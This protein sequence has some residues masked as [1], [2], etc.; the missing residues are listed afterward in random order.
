MSFLYPH[1]L[2]FLFLPALLAGLVA[3]A[4]RKT[5]NGWLKLVSAEH[6]DELVTRR[7]AWRSIIPAALCIL[8]LAC[9]IAALAR[10]INGFRE[11]GGL[12]T[13][14]NLLIALDISRSM[15]TQDVKP[16][17][18]EEARAAAYEL[19]DSLPSDKIG[20]IVFSGDAD[21]VVP[22]TY[23]HTALRDA[24][25]QVNRNWAGTGGT[26]FGLVLK[27]A[28][29]DLKRSA[30]D[31]TNA[32]V[33]LSDGEDTVGSS[34][35]IAEE[36][37][38]DKLLVI[39][40]GVGT[41]AGGPIPDPKGQNGLWQD[42]DG[43]HVISKL[44]ADSLRRFSEATGGDF[45]VLDSNTDLAAF[46]KNAV[47]KIDKHEENVSTNKVPNDLFAWFAWVALALLAAAIVIA[48][49]WRLPR[50]GAAA[51]AL[52]LILSPAA[53]AAPSGQSVVQYT[54]G[55]MQEGKDNANAKEAFS[56]ALLD[57]D[58]QMQAA[59]FYQIGNVGAN[60]T[61]DKLRRLYGEGEQE[62][63][64]QVST[65]P[66]EEDGAAAPQGPKQP[67][68]EDLEKVVEELKK[69]LLPYENALKIQPGLKPAESNIA[70]IKQLIKDLE[71]E[72]ERLKQQQQQQQQNQD[73]NQD[74]QQQQNQDQQQQNQQ[75]QNKDNQQ[76]QDQKDQQDQDQQQQNQ[77]QQNQQDKQDQD[78][79]QKDQDR[80]QQQGQQDRD[81]QQQQ[82]QNQD[83]QQ[84]QEQKEQQAKP[85]RE[86]EQPKPMTEE[87][88]A[89]Q[90]AADIL[91][92]HLD[93]E[94]GSPIPH[95]P[96]NTVRPPRKDY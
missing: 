83:Q 24:L 60:A 5:G 17:R 4:R 61:I 87:E 84:Q 63:G 22:L 91:R 19:I 80:Q 65:D 9:T 76:K 74:Q 90:S 79:Q 14:R 35:D 71:E 29:Q 53:Q 38:K 96:A 12:S 10:P 2:W 69:D 92:M 34:L 55:L 88:K 78:Q 51:V 41:A 57:S 52:L 47:R 42:A 37:R 39:T 23:D 67:S 1:I 86:G 64:E 21:L 73:Q 82:Q 59:A 18:L 15:E 93:E 43:K 45:A 56:E 46:T 3:L 58:P 28:M 26:N 33:L 95:A 49:E 72:I 40:V 48:T 20:L 32:L 16:S 7:P 89:Q 81:K 31:G 8:A 44:D 36:A 50:R 54:K 75:N 77:D 25:E 94:K 62:Q 13:G 85:E 68:I 6:T 30:P 11:A 70:K 66:E 27:R